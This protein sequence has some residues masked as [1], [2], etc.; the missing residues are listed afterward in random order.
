M[1]LGPQTPI[2]PNKSVNKAKKMSTHFLSLI[3]GWIWSNWGSGDPNPYGDSVEKMST[4]FLTTV[5]AWIWA[6]RPNCS[7]SIF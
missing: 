1:D 5:S 2:A 6:P 4:H 3:N 7:K